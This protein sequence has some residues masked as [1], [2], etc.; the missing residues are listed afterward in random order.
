MQAVTIW[1][2]DPQGSKSD[3]LGGPLDLTGA[4]GD[5]EIANV[6]SGGKGD[7]VS[8]LTGVYLSDLT[9]RRKAT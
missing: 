1:Q 5:K 6:K 4:L 7:F 3:K 2:L 9:V 8:A